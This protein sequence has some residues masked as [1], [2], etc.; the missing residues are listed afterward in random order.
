MGRSSR[1]R[2][3]RLAEKLL[4]IRITLDLSQN[5]MLKRLGLSDELI[6]SNIS[7]FELGTAEPSLPILLKYAQAA[8]VWL[9]V[10]VDDNLDLPAKLPSAR[11]HEGIKRQA[12]R[13]GKQRR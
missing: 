6:R 9:D 10:L 7:R 3:A 2:P 11:K 13:S 4:Q 12:L 5:E 8:N 1:Q